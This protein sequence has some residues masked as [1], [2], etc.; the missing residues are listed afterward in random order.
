M[1]VD[2]SLSCVRGRDC[3][4]ADRDRDDFVAG[5]ELFVP[6]NVVR[7]LQ[8]CPRCGAA[9]R[10]DEPVDGVGSDIPEGATPTGPQAG[11][12]EETDTGGDPDPAP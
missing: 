5:H 11:R 2:R 1:H 3:P 6:C 12:A 10:E 7:S 8:P 9:R 4:A